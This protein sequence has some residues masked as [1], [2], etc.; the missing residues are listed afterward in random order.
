MKV[1]IEDLNNTTYN[2]NLTKEQVELVKWMVERDIIYNAKVIDE[3]KWED[4]K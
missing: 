1:I 4:I 3:M 2:V